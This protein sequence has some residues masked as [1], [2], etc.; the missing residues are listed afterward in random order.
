MIGT[1]MTRLDEKRK[2]PDLKSFGIS[3][4]AAGAFGVMAR[5]DGWRPAS[6]A[7]TMGVLSYLWGIKW[8]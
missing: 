2:A 3:M 1:Q 7:I 5:P 4:I 8:E 6:A